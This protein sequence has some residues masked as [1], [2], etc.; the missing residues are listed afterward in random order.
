MTKSIKLI[1][2]GALISITLATVTFGLIHAQP[3]PMT[4]DQ[5]NRIRSS[6]VSTKNTLAQLHASDALLRVNRGQIYE[7]MSTKLMKRFND[8]A[9]SNRYDIRGLTSITESYGMVLT[10]FRSDYQAYEEQLSSALGIDCSKE[11]VKFYDSVAL[12]RTSRSRVH[13][14]VVE[15]HYYIDEYGKAFESFVGSEVVKK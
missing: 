14:N 7:Y 13:D 10:T 9:N 3:A 1:I 4:D 8:R 15:L 6:C 5:I 12:A 11:P 2:I